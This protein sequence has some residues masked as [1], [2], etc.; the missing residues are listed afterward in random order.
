MVTECDVTKSQ[1][2]KRD[3]R[4]SDYC[5]KQELLLVLTLTFLPF[6]ISC[7][8]QEQIKSSDGKEMLLLYQ[9]M[10]LSPVTNEPVTL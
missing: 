1:N 8:A 9:I 2:R 3:Y 5:G 4:S 7:I 10:I 6:K